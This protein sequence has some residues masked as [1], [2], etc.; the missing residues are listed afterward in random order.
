MKRVIA[1]LALILIAVPAFAADIAKDPAVVSEGVQTNYADIILRGDAAVASLN[2][3]TFTDL[4][5]YYAAGLTAAGFTP[6]VLYDPAGGTDYSAYLIVFADASDNWWSTSPWAAWHADFGAYMAAGGKMV[7]IGQD[8]IY[9]AAGY[10]FQ[11][12]YLGL[13]GVVE[14]INY[15]DTS[16]MSWTGTNPGPLAGFSGSMVPCFS[17]NPWFTDQIIPASQGVATWSTAAYPGPYQGGCASMMGA[18][19]VIEFGCGTVDAVG[20]LAGW[21]VTTATEET[22]VSAVKALY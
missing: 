19:S 4:S 3:T 15:N 5:G 17:A 12:T 18:F 8:W 10:G 9:G 21:F 14:D 20:P 7:C 11:Q 22:S 2:Q 1:A 16:S 13:S 6:D